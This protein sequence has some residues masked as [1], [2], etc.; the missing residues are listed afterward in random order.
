M[1]QITE[2]AKATSEAGPDLER[3]LT[4][5]HGREKRL[6]PYRQLYSQKGAST[7]QTP[8]EKFFLKLWSR[9]ILYTYYTAAKTHTIKSTSK[10][11]V[12]GIKST[13][14]AV[15]SQTTREFV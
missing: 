8:P 6:V 11:T 10:Y 3:A 5:H 12:G 4:V 2:R 14:A 15:K 9:H 1:F 13:H 7:V